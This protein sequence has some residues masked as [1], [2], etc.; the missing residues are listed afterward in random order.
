M[1]FNKHQQISPRI[2]NNLFYYNAPEAEVSNLRKILKSKTG[3]ATL[4][5]LSRDVY[6]NLDYK[7]GLQNER[8]D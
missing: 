5:M 1:S 3:G 8:Q 6:P 7:L 2:L 4:R